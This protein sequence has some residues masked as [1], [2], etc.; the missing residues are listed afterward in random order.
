MSTRIHLFCPRK[1][2]F[3]VHEKS[4]THHIF[5]YIF[6]DSSKVDE[7]VLINRLFVR[8]MQKWIKAR[9]NIFKSSEY[10]YIS[11]KSNCRQIPNVP[12]CSS[13]LVNDLAGLVVQ[14]VQGGQLD[15][16]ILGPDSSKTF[17]LNSVPPTIFWLSV[18]PVMR[19]GANCILLIGKLL[20]Y[21]N[22][23]CSSGWSWV[24]VWRSSRRIIFTHS[25]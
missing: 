25:F 21:Y 9:W 13:G 14:K 22:Y 19:L 2:T 3:Y 1:F 8:S 15:L 24:F 16:P 7:L 18:V 6:S 11:A 20:G 10:K 12:I 5:I 4:T 23:L 17:F